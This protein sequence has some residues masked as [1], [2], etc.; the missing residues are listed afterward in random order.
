MNLVWALAILVVSY[1]I[2]ALTTKKTR[3]KDAVPSRLSEFQFP[4]HE[5]GVPQAV[6]FGECW[7]SDWEVLYF[8]NLS[9]EAIRASSDSGKKK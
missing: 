8:G 9:T 6:I 1:A 5:E 3:P 7:T 2:T 4:Q